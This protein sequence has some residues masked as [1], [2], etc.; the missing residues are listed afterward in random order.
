MVDVELTRILDLLEEDADLLQT[1]ENVRQA[2]THAELQR[3]TRELKRRL[4]EHGIL[5]THAVLNSLFTRLLRPGSSSASDDLVRTLVR[6]WRDQEAQLGVET[7]AR[8]FA[9]LASGEEA[10]D[11]SLPHIDPAFRKK[12]Q[13]RFQVLYGLL[14]PRGSAI[15]SRSL[16]TYNPFSELPD[17][18]RELLLDVL[19]AGEEAVSLSDPDWRESLTRT[20]TRSAMA[21]LKAPLEDAPRV[22]QAITHLA[23]T[24]LEIGFLHL[25]PQVQ[26]VRRS[27]D[28]ITVEIYLREAIQ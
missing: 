23:A 18:E 13:W 24:P 26:G 22:R 27:R 9:Y 8:I 7:D 14:W 25:Y 6:R 20:L 5:A 17:P 12:P 28:G 11:I 15:R 1:V 19:E 10:L 21:R 3:C 2:G 16:K 4:A